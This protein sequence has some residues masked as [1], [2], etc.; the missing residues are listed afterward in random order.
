MKSKVGL[1]TYLR[2]ME[3]GE[4]TVSTSEQRYVS[5]TILSEFM[6]RY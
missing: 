6:G 2:R 3:L 1:L 5:T 4:Q